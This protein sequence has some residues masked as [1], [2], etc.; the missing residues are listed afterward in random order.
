MAQTHLFFLASPCAPARPVTPPAGGTRIMIM[1]TVM[2]AA[3]EP[4]AEASAF[5]EQQEHDALLAMTHVGRL[6]LANRQPGA[7]AGRVARFA[8]D[9]MDAERRELLGMTAAGRLA[10][11]A[12]GLG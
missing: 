3:P 11:E 8:D 1:P 12:R 6:A 4:D 5:A 7:S 2:F 10:L 9:E